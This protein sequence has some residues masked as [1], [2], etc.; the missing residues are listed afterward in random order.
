MHRATRLYHDYLYS[1]FRPT[2][3]RQAGPETSLA[4]ISVQSSQDLKE[5]ILRKP[6][7]IRI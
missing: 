1:K 5:A 6:Y 2:V 7:S 3:Q 4:V